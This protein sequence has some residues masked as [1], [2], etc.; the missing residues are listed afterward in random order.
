MGDLTGHT[1]GTHSAKKQVDFSSSLQAVQPSIVYACPT[2]SQDASITANCSYQYA[3]NSTLYVKSTTYAINISGSSGCINVSGPTETI[4]TANYTVLSINDT[5]F[6]IA[7]ISGADGTIQLRWQAPYGNDT[8]RFNTLRCTNATVSGLLIYAN[9]TD[10]FIYSDL[11]V[12]ASQSALLV[13]CAPD[14]DYRP[15][16]PSGIPVAVITATA[17]II[18]GAGIVAYRRR[19]E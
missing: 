7:F 12:N 1:Y 4:N 19:S 16:V 14:P 2:G 6:K 8:H 3:A 13:E 15:D 10:G 11:Y 9:E 17:I 5:Y 18:I